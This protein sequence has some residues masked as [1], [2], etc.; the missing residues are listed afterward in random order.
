M[1]IHLYGNIY[2]FVTKR[3]AAFWTEMFEMVLGEQNKCKKTHMLSFHILRKQ[4]QTSFNGQRWVSNMCI[5]HNEQQRLAMA[6]WERGGLTNPQ[7]R[8]FSIYYN[9]DNWE[10]PERESLTLR[11]PAY[12]TCQ[13]C[14]WSRCLQ[15]P[16]TTAREICNAYPY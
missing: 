7:G 12:F 4:Q 10:E 15:T 2:I 5:F 13:L 3:G 9:R 1:S 14:D 8:L 6:D 16:L 11:S